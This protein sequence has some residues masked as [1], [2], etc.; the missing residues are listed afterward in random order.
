MLKHINWR[1]FFQAHFLE[2]RGLWY[3]FLSCNSFDI[4]KCIQN[5]EKSFKYVNKH[6]K[7]LTFHIETYRFNPH[8]K[9]D[10]TRDLKEI[11]SFIDKDPYSL[12]K[13][14]LN[15]TILREI[16]TNNQNEILN[17]LKELGLSW[18]T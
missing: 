11:K 10:E 5:F 12:I 14:K 15:E 9:S 8:S 1:E 7:P 13:S 4:N 18:S 3:P 16:E 6:K 2:D 17:A